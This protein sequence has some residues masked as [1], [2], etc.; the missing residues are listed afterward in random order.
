[1]STI[2]ETGAERVFVTHGYTAVVARWLSEEGLEAHP[3]ETRFAAEED[4]TDLATEGVTEGDGA[5][6]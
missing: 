6:G 4:E 1:M 5:E 2:R 3:L